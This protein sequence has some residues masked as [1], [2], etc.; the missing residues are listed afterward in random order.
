MRVLITN[1]RLAARTGTELYVRDLAGALLDR[2]HQP[3]A[4]SNELGE[5]ARELR[6]ATVPVIDRLEALG[7]PPD[8]IHGQHHLETMTALCHFPDTPAVFFCHGWLPAPEAP[9]RFPRILRYVAVDETVRDRLVCESGIAEGRVRVILNFVDLGR[10]KPRG[11]LPARPQRA[12]VFSNYATEA[13]YLGAVREACARAGIALDVAGASADKTCARPEE[14]L[15]RYD[16]VFAKARCALEALAVGSAVVLC[17]G[18]G[19][20]PLVTAG[21]FDRLRRYNFGIRTIRQPIRPELIDREIARYDPADAAEV[22]RRVRAGAGLEAAVDEILDLYREVCDE[23]AATRSGRDPA[24]EWRAAADY[25]AWLGGVR[26]QEREALYGSA[27]F[28][29]WQRLHNVP[30]LS[31]VARAGLHKFYGRRP[32]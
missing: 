31:R 13:T 24:A 4:Y 27:F 15:G 32:G 22:S 12:L 25:L 20:G 18:T 17:D 14:L 26:R 29:V 8:V 9:P 1:F 23:Y 11:P 2:G 3:T 16:L 10:F 21:E 30:V 28:K 6:R 7:A 19:L 5:V